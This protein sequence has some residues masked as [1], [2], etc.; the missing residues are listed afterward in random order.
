LVRG[1]RLLVDAIS[2]LGA[3]NLSVDKWHCDI[4]VTSSQQGWMAPSGLAMVSVSQKWWQA[5]SKA[6][7][8]RSYWDFA[9]AK[10]YLEKG[11]TP[12]TPAF[13][14]IFALDISLGMMLEEGLPNIIAR[15]ARVAKVARDGIKSL[16]LS[17]S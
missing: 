16:G 13:S 14:K 2:S 17:L 5:Y 11:G 12:W 3:I 15:Y 7:M 9:R 8:F 4:A 6:K 10:S 1:E